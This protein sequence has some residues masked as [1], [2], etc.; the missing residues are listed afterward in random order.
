M[1][2][3]VKRI[4]NSTLALSLAAAILIGGFLALAVPAAAIVTPGATRAL[5]NSGQLVRDG[6]TA[7]PVFGITATSTAPG[8]QLLSVT[9]AFAGTGFN[10][11]SAGDVFALST[12]PALSGVALYRD[13]GAVPGSLD[14]TDVGVTASA[15]VWN[16]NQVALTYTEPFPTI[17][18]GAFDWILVIRTSNNAA[19]LANNDQIVATI[20]AAGILFTGAVS[21]PAAAVSANALTVSLT[22]ATDLIAPHAWIGPLGV[23]VNARAVLGIRLVDGGIPLNVGVNDTFSAIVVQILDNSATYAGNSLRAPNVNPALSGIG[24]YRDSNGNGI[25]DPADTPVTL[26]AIVLNCLAPVDVEDWCLFPNAELVPNTPPV[27]YSYFVVV[28]SDAMASGDDFQFEV[29]RNQ[30]FASG[31]HGNDAFR[32]TLLADVI[33]SSLLGDDTPPC[34]TI[35]CGQPFGIHWANPTSSPYLYPVDRLLYFGHLMGATRVPG[36]VVLSTQDTESGLAGAVFTSEPSL[37]GSPAPIVLSGTGVNVVVQ[38][39]YS[40]NGTSTGASSPAFV[41]V[42]DAVGN[43]VIAPALLYVLDTTN[44]LVVPSP[45]W[46]NLPGPNFYVNGTGTLWF[47]PWIAGTQNVDIRIDLSDAISGL[48]TA[49]ATSEPSL[50][51]GPIYR[52]PTSFPGS[53]AFSGWTVSYSFNG[54][55]TDASSPSITT[56]DEVANCASASFAYRLDSTAPSVSILAPAGGSVLSGRVIVAA[57]GSD[58]GSGLSGPL[59]VQILGQTGFINM[60]WNGTAWVWPIATGLY[61]D[62]SNTIIVRGVD[63]VGNEVATVV[64]VTFV[65]SDVTS[66]T[67]AFV[68]PGA[69]ALASGILDVRVSAIDAGGL[70]SVS[71]TVGSTTVTMASVGGGVYSYPLDTTSLPAGAVTLSVTA[72]DLASHATTRTLS[73]RVDN[74]APT[75]ALISPS[76][77]RGAIVL[78]ATVSDSPAGV[79]SVMFVVDGKTYTAV[80]DGQGGYSVMIST[81]T[82]DNGAHSYQVMATDR[83]GNTATSSGSFAVS[84]PTDYY[85]AVLA[86]SPFGIFVLVLAALIVAL[87]IRR[88]GK[89]SKPMPATLEPSPPPPEPKKLDDDL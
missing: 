42:F 49:T 89:G 41:T 12:N 68:A 21:Q 73:I 53:G 45:G 71:L 76:S 62:G 60:V 10:A 29:L 4:R 66:P 38:A 65:N 26:A 52:S 69:N 87:L 75:I 17:P 80:A 6:S 9:V 8:D 15:A 20:P 54:A 36:Q 77:D 44:P 28:R 57:T 18:A 63:N 47:S 56:C 2:S 82:A 43:L 55:S 39:N 25:W 27:S 74:T 30:I 5:V 13:V 7:V 58:S 1:S 14:A 40:F 79:A 46:Q 51:G 85:A 78:R 19:P 86:F 34:V 61:P 83:A 23:A 16:V 24:L 70:A 3:R 31:V 67:V 22:S 35:A 72:T 84:N 33:S 32:P 50:A 48:K 37:A 11:G 88:R 59:Q 64:Q 81:T